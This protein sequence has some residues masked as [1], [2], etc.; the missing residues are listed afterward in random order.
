MS[1]KTRDRIWGFSLTYAPSPCTPPSRHF[2][3]AL[4]LHLGKPLSIHLALEFKEGW[5]HAQRATQFISKEKAWVPLLPLPLV[6]FQ[7]D[8][9]RLKCH[10]SWSSRRGAV[11]NESD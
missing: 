8:D 11:V 6:P 3:D 7:G 10:P 5:A 1:Q 9:V 2:V 4:L